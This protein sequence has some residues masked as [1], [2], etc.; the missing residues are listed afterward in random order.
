ML[1]LR[2]AL[3]KI[4]AIVS[5]LF[6][7]SNNCNNNNTKCRGLN[8]NFLCMIL[9]MNQHSF[10]YQRYGFESFESGR[11]SSFRVKSKMVHFT[12]DVGHTQLSFN[13]HLQTALK[14]ISGSVCLFCIMTLLQN[15]YHFSLF[16]GAWGTTQLNREVIIFSA[17]STSY[18][19]NLQAV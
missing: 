19:D 9:R 6:S 15:R 12:G 4:L 14:Q 5:S 10:L 7:W 1:L 2:K 3:V 17:C 13:C 11:A 18:P 8:G 16:Q